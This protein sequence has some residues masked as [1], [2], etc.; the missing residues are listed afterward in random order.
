MSRFV[1]KLTDPSNK[2]TSSNETSYG[3]HSNTANEV[4]RTPS[5]TQQHT[6]VR[7]IPK[8]FPS[9]PIPGFGSNP[10]TPKPDELNYSPSGR[11]TNTAPFSAFGT[12]TSSQ[13]VEGYMHVGQGNGYE[14]IK[15]RVWNGSPSSPHS[16][17]SNQYSHE[18]VTHSTISSTM[19]W[20]NNTSIYTNTPELGRPRRSGVDSRTAAGLNTANNSTYYP[21]AIGYETEMEMMLNSP[22][23]PIG[24]QRHKGTPSYT[25]PAGQ[26]DRG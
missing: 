5:G 26:G 12:A 21:G 2:P 15:Q 18:Q 22:I 25:P 4:F 3:M 23:A 10:W 6:R 7:S 16:P 20:E 1:D 14:G 13:Q 8:A 11:N 19:D 24:S 17:N 9:L